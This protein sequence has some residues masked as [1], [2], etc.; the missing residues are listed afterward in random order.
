MGGAAHGAPEMKMQV[1]GS[2]LATA[3]REIRAAGGGRSVAAPFYGGVGAGV[4]QKILTRGP[5]FLAAELCTQL[6]MSQTGLP[7]ER[8][9]FVGAAGSGYLTGF[10]A[11][12]A[13]WAKVLLRAH[14]LLIE[15]EVLGVLGRVAR[16]P[17]VTGPKV[18]IFRLRARGVAW[19]IRR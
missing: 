13:E 12:G 14:D 19:H 10:F 11:A 18:V 3:L 9:L 15:Q 17:S 8:A 1:T 6:C 4:T 16:H 2:P 5:M 7:R